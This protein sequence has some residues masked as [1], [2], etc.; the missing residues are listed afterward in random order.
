MK[1]N[2]YLISGDVAP[3]LPAAPRE[4]GMKERSISKHYFERIKPVTEEVSPLRT[5][6]LFHLPEV[7]SDTD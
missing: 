7:G 5:A 1:Y 3:Q 6:W 4:S 2:F